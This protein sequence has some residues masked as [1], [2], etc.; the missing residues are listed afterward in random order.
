MNISSSKHRN[1]KYSFVECTRTMFILVVL[2][3][4]I[5][6]LMFWGLAVLCV[7]VLTMY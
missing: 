5:Y 1:W 3:V 2:M 7:K 6:D 4:C